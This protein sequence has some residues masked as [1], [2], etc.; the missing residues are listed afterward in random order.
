MKFDANGWLDMALD[1]EYGANSMSRQGYGIKYLVLHG[2]AGGISAVAIGNYF[3]STVGGANP[4]S[5]HI[6]IDQQGVVV[7]GVPLSLA[8]F[9]NGAF[10]NGHAP[11]LPNTNPNYYTASIE[12]VKSSLDN[13][14][15]LTDKQK[16]VGFEVIACICDTYKIP[17]R[18]GDANGGIIEHATIDPV[19]RSNCV[20]TFSWDE[21]YSYLG[22]NEVTQ[23][24]YDA[25]Y[26]KL[27]TLETV[28]NAVVT[29]KN[30]LVA[31]TNTLQSKLTTLQSAYDKVVPEKNGL[32]AQVAQ[33]KIDLATAQ[34]AAQ[35]IDTTAIKTTL[36]S[37]QGELTQALA[38]L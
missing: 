24:D 15:G 23:A 30:N 36:T 38:Q 19:N 8:A 12:F 35:P 3:T 16:Q 27:T 14:D 17:K 32:I 5:S 31:S 29:T 20:G 33:L 34:K 18:S 21:M 9:A 7:Q 1:S 28:Y 37:L 11:Y 6:I 22:E 10:S 25:L 4:V 2:T 13:S 26:K